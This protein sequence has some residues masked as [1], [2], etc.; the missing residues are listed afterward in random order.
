MN[1]LILLALLGWSPM[2]AQASEISSYTVEYSTSTAPLIIQA[3]A[4]KNGVASST[5]LLQ[6]I[7]W[8]ESRYSATAASRTND[9]GPMQI[10]RTYHTKAAQARNLS[11]TDPFDNIQYGI[12]LFKEQGTAPWNASKGC[13]SKKT[14]PN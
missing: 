10:N 4:S 13:W 2:T 12:E 5:Q 3:L 1:L 6:D 7:A 14:S 9:I 8:C 11:L